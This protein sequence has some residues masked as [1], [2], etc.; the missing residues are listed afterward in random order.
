MFR[1]V[2]AVLAVLVLAPS[3]FASAQSGLGSL[4]GYVR[5][6]QGGA[7]PG[8]TVTATSPEML[9]P[10]TGAT[11]ANGFYRLLNLPPGT[12]TVTVEMPGFSTYKQEGILRSSRAS[13]AR[14]KSRPAFSSSRATPTIRFA[15]T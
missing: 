10:S 3:E 14:T 2:L 1:S 9:A 12:Y 5:D 13:V 11:D 6:Q 4:R 7:L 15:T 8:A